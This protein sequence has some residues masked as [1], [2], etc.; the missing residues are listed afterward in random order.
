MPQILRYGCLRKEKETKQNKTKPKKKTN[1]QT[2]CPVFSDIKVGYKVVHKVKGTELYAPN[3]KVKV[4]I[5]S[6]QCP[7]RALCIRS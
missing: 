7:V 2:V 4:S 1:K 6:V 5:Q 3:F